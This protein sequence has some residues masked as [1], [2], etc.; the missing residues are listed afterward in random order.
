MFEAEGSYSV[1]APTYTY[2]LSFS[3]RN[4]ALLDEVEWALTSMGFHPERRSCAVRLRKK[5]EVA[6]FI[7]LIRFRGYNPETDAF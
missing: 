4:P 6:R 1:H 5:Q 2:N 3:N 7:E